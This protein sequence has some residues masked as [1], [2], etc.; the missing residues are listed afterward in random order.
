MN[1]SHNEPINE[2]FHFQSGF[3][4]ITVFCKLDLRKVLVNK[5][6]GILIIWRKGQRHIDG[7]R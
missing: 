5:H 1:E 3:M 7:L 2:C 4:K 6:S